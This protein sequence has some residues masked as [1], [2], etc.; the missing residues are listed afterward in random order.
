M[1]IKEQETKSQ[2]FLNLDSDSERERM[3]GLLGLGLDSL[4][5][6]VLSSVRARIWYGYFFMSTTSSMHTIHTVR[7]PTPNRVCILCIC[8]LF[9]LRALVLRI[10]MYSLYSRLARVQARK[11]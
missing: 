1:Q 3:P 10:A 2:L 8:A 9:T 4:T 7:S 11:P 5:I 6:G